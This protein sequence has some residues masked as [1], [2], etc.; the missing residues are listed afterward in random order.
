GN[1]LEDAT[2]L[3]EQ[4][5]PGIL[6]HLRN[7]TDLVIIDGPALLSSADA[8]LLATMADGVALVVDARHEK[9]PFLL[10]ARELLASL[11]HKPAGVVMNRFARRSKL[12][13]A[14]PYPAIAAPEKSM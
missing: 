9:L 11:T 2:L 8:S 12:Y 10:R 4:K 14:T 6:K 1:P 13:Y 7:K 3:I 5:L